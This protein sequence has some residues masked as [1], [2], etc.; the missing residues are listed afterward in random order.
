[1]RTAKRL[2]VKTVAVYSDADAKALHVYMADEAFHIGQAAATKSYLRGDEILKVAR[3]ANCQAIHPGYGFLSENVEFAEACQKQGV[4]FIG[5]PASAIRDMGIKSTSKC[6]MSQ[7]G[8]PVIEGYHGNDQSNENLEREALRI[9][10]PVMIKAVR[11]GGGKGMRIAGRQEEFLDA[12]ESARTESQKAFGDSVVLLEKFIAEPRHVEVQ[13]FADSYGDVVHLYER[14]CSVQRRHQKI[15]EEA[16]APGLSWNLRKELGDAAVRAAKAVGYV[17]A[18]T[19]EFILDRNSHSF[20]FMEMNTR[21]QVEHPITEMITGVDLVEWQ[22]KIASGEKLLLKQEEI[23]LKGHAFEARI[24]AEDP[25]GGFLPGAGPLLYLSTPKPQDDVRIETG[26]RQGDEVSVHYDPMIAKLV[27]WGN[28][29]LEALLKL[30][31]KLGEYNIAGLETNVNFLLDLSKH[32]EFEAGS[33]HTNFIQDHNE[34]LFADETPTKIQLIQGGLATILLDKNRE[35]EMAARRND[36]FNPFV[37]ESNFRVNYVH[38]RDVKL[39]FKGTDYIVKVKILGDEEYSVSCD[40]GN[41]WMDV[42]AELEL[43]DNKF[44]LHCTLDGFKTTVNVFGNEQILALFGSDGKTE[45]SYP[46]P[47][48]MVEEDSQSFSGFADRAVAPMPGILDKV[49][50]K[51]GDDVKAGDPLFVLIAMKMEHVVKANRDAKI[52]D[53]LHNVGDSVNKDAAIIKFDQNL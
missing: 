22:I 39:K 3:L 2:G 20:H 49:L 29:R 10:F 43:G 52:S 46:L 23:P 14:D 32:G 28:D 5:P 38:V 33:V 26:V 30:R 48:F 12:L 8:V 42:S 53:I 36:S 47:L 45:F 11:G 13:V 41:S 27:V 35:K 34:S 1:M 50:V 17:G 44:L 4:I 19:V 9:G 18:G 21:L 24:Y 37:L 40:D 15:I 16:P 51:A 7:A 31:S 6:I 25:R